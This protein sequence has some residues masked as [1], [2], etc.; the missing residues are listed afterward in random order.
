MADPQTSYAL[1]LAVE[2]VGP[3]T[4][5]GAT[6]DL[7]EPE[8]VT[9]LGDFYQKRVFGDAV[10]SESMPGLWY[11][12]TEPRAVTFVCSNA[13]GHFNVPGDWREAPVR[14]WCYDRNRGTTSVFYEGFVSRVQ[15]VN[16]RATVSCVSFDPSIF[17][18]LLPACAID[19]KTGSPFAD[20]GSPGV[21]PPVIF[22]EGVP[23]RAPSAT[24]DVV[25]DPGGYDFLV[26]FDN[27]YVRA[28]HQDINP[29]LPGMERLGAFVDAPGSPAYAHPH[30]F[31]VAGDQR[32]RYMWNVDGTLIA[33][34]AVRFK[35]TASGSTYLYSSV[36]SYDTTTTPHEVEI[37]DAR[38]DAGLHSVQIAGDYLIVRGYQ[39]VTEGLSPEPPAPGADLTAVRLFDAGDARL[40]VTADN[41]NFPLATTQI[42]D[43][44]RAILLNETWGLSVRQTQTVNETS[45]TVGR[46]ACAISGLTGAIAGALAY[47]QQQRPADQILGGLLMLRGMRLTQN[48]E[49]EWVI[50]VDAQPLAAA[51]SFQ[52]G[53]GEEYGIRIRRVTDYGRVSLT[54]AVRNVVLHWSPLG[55]GLAASQSW[56]PRDYARITTKAVGGVGR[57]RH[58]YCPWIRDQ[59]IAELC[60]HYIGEKFR[61]ADERLIFTAGQEARDVTLGEVITVDVPTDGITGDWQVYATAKSLAGVT[62]EAIRANAAAYD[63]TPT[64]V[65]TSDA[66]SEIEHRTSTGAGTNLIRNPEF[67]PPYRYEGGQ[68]L[69]DDWGAGGLTIEPDASALVASRCFGGHYLRVTADLSQTPWEFAS[70][71][72]LGTIEVFPVPAQQLLLAS[73]YCDAADGVFCFFDF[74]NEISTFAHTMPTLLRDDTDVDGNGWP[75]FYCRVRPP[76]GTRAALFTIAFSE[77]GTYNVAALQIEAVGRTGRKPSPWRRHRPVPATIITT[78]SV[79]FDGSDSYDVSGFIPAGAHVIGVSSRVTEAITFGTATGFTIGTEA[80]P[81]AWSDTPITHTAVDAVT[82]PSDWT[83]GSSPTLY[84]TSTTVTVAGR[85]GTSAGT[86]TDGTLRLVLE[87]TRNLPVSAE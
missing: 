17:R 9:A 54:E 13:E 56:T 25:S 6:T 47:D 60:A 82:G 76:A 14:A 83:G 1:A 72:K 52:M 49:R 7:P 24:N 33:G 4:F 66:P 87:Y 39:N 8:A 44:V 27:L 18:E 43:V 12:M 38:L 36:T 15:P 20:S 35:T 62:I 58:L 46:I 70:N 65:T 77:P 78:A 81:S 53:P 64:G 22:G 85:A 74:F 59:A 51:R 84:A 79:E 75:R 23:V 68:N 11:G 40:I 2:I 28:V 19:P 45:F 37:A 42:V 80:D 71:Q 3:V 73:F 67:G 16:G 29:D 5:R 57:D 30:R 69:P 10:V 61:G 26:G 31:Q 63:A 48:A 86:I 21:P 41:P 34:M 55:R 50:V 32:A